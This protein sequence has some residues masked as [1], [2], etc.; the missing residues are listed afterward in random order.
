MSMLCHEY[1]LNKRGAHCQSVGRSF[2]ARLSVIVFTLMNCRFP[3]TGR[4][5][6]VREVCAMSSERRNH[7][8]R[9]A[10]DDYYVDLYSH[11]NKEEASR[12]V[13]SL[14]R[15]VVLKGARVLDL[16]CGTGRYIG[17]LSS[18][19]A[20]PVGLDLS[21]ALLEEASR[22][23]AEP[24]VRGDMRAIPFARAA[25]DGAV[26]MFTSFG[27]FSDIDDEL[28]VL[29]EVHRCLK[30]GGWFVIDYMNSSLVRATLVPS[31]VRRLGSLRAV[32][33]RRIDE[34]GRRVAKDIELYEGE[35]LVK[36]HTEVVR[37]LEMEE[38]SAMLAAAG[39]R[40]R[41]L[42]GGYAGEEYDRDGSHRMIALCRKD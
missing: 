35:R 34:D 4:R 3:E 15:L 31:S 17:A 7:W 22:A 25:F 24:L 11:R 2:A 42:L 32:E 23:G 1:K 6:A 33:R 27:Y 12:F 9:E 29:R 26:S 39:L 36:R 37:L 16:A 41:R 30:P 28:A 18:A 19:G 13:G 14:G 8:Y 38:L 5:H 20:S 10:F 21:T 40:I